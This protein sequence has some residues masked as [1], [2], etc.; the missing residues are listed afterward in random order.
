M[1]PRAG[2]ERPSSG[3][4]ERRIKELKAGNEAAK[5]AALEEGRR[6][7]GRLLAMEVEAQDGAAARAKAS[8]L[9]EQHSREQELLE[10]QR[11]I[12]EQWHE[13]KVKPPQAC[14]LRNDLAD[15][16]DTRQHGPYWRSKFNGRFR[17]RR[18]SRACWDSRASWC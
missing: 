8:L 12:V 4:I 7:K 13:R 16:G 10:E 14:V 18:S 9:E 3:G 15:N 6:A 1:D 2:V 17:K 5:K 11:L